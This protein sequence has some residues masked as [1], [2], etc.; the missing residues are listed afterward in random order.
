MNQTTPPDEAAEILKDYRTKIADLIQDSPGVGALREQLV[1]LDAEAL[2]KLNSLRVR[3]RLDEATWAHDNR[4]N[5]EAL[6]ERRSAL[7]SQ[8]T[9]REQQ[10]LNSSRKPV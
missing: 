10:S 1:A 3:D 5:H 9:V 2:A 7:Q 6:D 4:M 8:L